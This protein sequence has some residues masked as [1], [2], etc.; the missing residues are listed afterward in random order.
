MKKIFLPMIVVLT[1]AIAF[2][3]FADD[4]VDEVVVVGNRPGGSPWG[5]GGGNVGATPHNHN[6]ADQGNGIAD[7]KRIKACIAAVEVKY[8]AC[9]VTA[10]KNY[11]TNL[12]TCVGYAATGAALTAVGLKGKSWIGGLMAFAGVVS[13]YY[14]TQACPA[15]SKADE[16]VEFQTCTQTKTIT[17]TEK[18]I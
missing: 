10:A 4:D 12:Q 6:D 15:I 5:S 8:S 11:S 3:T 17:L 7:E 2:P 1:S 14:G 13:T 18:C 16:D 9:N